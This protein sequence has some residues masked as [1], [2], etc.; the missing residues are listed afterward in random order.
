MIKLRVYFFK[1]ILPWKNYFTNFSNQVLLLTKCVEESHC[2]C[3]FFHSVFMN[4]VRNFHGCFTDMKN[5][6]EVITKYPTKY[7]TSKPV[8]K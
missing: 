1:Y 2:S 6:T 3:L 8:F 5:L 7:E 4:Q